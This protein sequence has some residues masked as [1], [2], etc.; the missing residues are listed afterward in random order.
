[1]NCSFLFNASSEVGSYCTTPELETIFIVIGTLGLVLIIP[2]FFLGG[3]IVPALV[4][5]KQ[6]NQAINAVFIAL[7]VIC[8]ISVVPSILFDISLISGYPTFFDCTSTQLTVRSCIINAFI[9]L[10]LLLNLLLAIVFYASVRST[11]RSF[12]SLTVVRVVIILMVIFSVAHAVAIA[13]FRLGMPRE[14][15]AIRGSFCMVNMNKKEETNLIVAIL[16]FVIPFFLSVL[17]VFLTCCRV[18][19]TLVEL[20]KRVVRS[21]LMFLIAM[22]AATCVTRIPPF[23]I[24]I[25]IALLDFGEREAI[26]CTLVGVLILQLQVPILLSLV[27]ALN[28]RVRS[29]GE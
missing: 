16:V 21:M 13:G 29:V 6:G 3:V 15:L 25:F 2:T 27:F 9:V 12:C 1:M 7:A 14:I 26:I 11:G 10:V 8:L 23:L 28:K 18:L 5:D 24:N 20:D 17:F 22:L 19:N 4:K